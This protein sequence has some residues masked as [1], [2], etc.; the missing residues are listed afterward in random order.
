[1]SKLDMMK[2]AH[3]TANTSFRVRTAAGDPTAADA[4]GAGGAMVV[5]RSAAAIYIS[6][7]C[8]RRTGST[9]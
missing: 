8:G 2:P 6:F 5:F 7:R 1:M 9:T 3:T 4:D